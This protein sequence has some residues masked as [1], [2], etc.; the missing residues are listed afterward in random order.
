MWAV[1]CWFY[2]AYLHTCTRVLN[3]CIYM[4]KILRMCYTCVFF[5]YRRQLNIT[6]VLHMCRNITQTSTKINQVLHFFINCKLLFCDGNLLP[7]I[8][9]LLSQTVFLPMHNV[10][11]STYWTTYK[12]QHLPEHKLDRECYIIIIQ[13]HF[14]ITECP[15]SIIQVVMFT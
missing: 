13:V 2:G 9:S 1:F 12:L 7:F 11:G 15:A 10:Q 3:M 14:S 8:Q 4:C 5:F 6:H